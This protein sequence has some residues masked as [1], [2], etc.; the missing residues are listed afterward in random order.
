MGSF[1]LRVKLS[2]VYHTRWR[3]H[4]F[5]VFLFISFYQARKLWIIILIVL[6]L[7]Q[8]GIEPESN[9]FSSRRSIQLTSNRL[10][11]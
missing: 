5:P 6:G 10:K 3:L 4:T 9:R 8:T 2:P 1:G 7:T 11:L